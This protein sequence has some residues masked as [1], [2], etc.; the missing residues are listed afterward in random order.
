MT[1]AVGNHVASNL[2][3]QQ[4]KIANQIQHL[5]AYELIAETQGA[6]LDSVTGENDAI[7]ARCPSDQSHIPHR[8]LILA[9]SKRASRRDVAQVAPVAE[10]DL[11]G[12]FPDQRM[13]EVD[14]VGDGITIAWVDGDE[15]VSLAHLHLAA[16]LQI[17]PRSP[18]LPDSCLE[19]HLD[20]GLRAAIEDREFKII[21]FHD[22]IVD[23]NPDKRRE[24]MFGG[25]NK[26]ALLHQA[27]GVADAGD[28]SADGLDLESVKVSPAKHDASS[29][30]CWN[31]AHR[32]RRPAVQ[33][34]PTAFHRRANCLLL[35]QRQRRDYWSVND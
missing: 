16:N 7:L 21:E 12:F 17:L 31:N 24:K 1:G 34:N 4:R 35:N 28:I 13:R 18:L 29:R 19:N 14:R 30:G 33:A 23:A 3:S 5:V 26:N 2:L 22:G 15:L 8:L 20:E 27:G 10:R 32:D 6:I 9:R 25:R 11:E